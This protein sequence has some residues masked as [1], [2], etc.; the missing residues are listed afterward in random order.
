MRPI[1]WNDGTKFDDV[2]ARWGSP[3]YVLEIGD[4]G[5][6][7]QPEAP[8]T[9][10]PRKHNKNTMS[11]NATPTNRTILASLARTI[12]TGQLSHGVTIGLHHHLAPAM[13]T[14]IKKLEGDPAAAAGSAANKGSQLVYR[15]AVDATGDAEA[16]LMTLSDTTVKTWLEGYRKIMSGVHGSKANAGW[17]AAGFAQG[18]TAIPRNH[19]QRHVLLSA[20]R[21]YLAAHAN[22]EGS[23]PQPTGP[24]LAITA[25]RA[26]VLHTD[27]QAAKTLI[28]TTTNAQTTAKTLRDADVDALYDEVSDTIAELHEVLSD[29]DPL[30]EIFGLNIPA[31]PNPPLGISTLT[32]TAAGTGRELLSWPYA[33]RAEYYRVF[34]KRVGIDTDFINVDD[35]KDLE[36]TLKNLTPGSII[37]VY[38]V[39]MNDGGAGPASP[40]V[41]KTVGA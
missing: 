25:A 23:L 6:I 8:G 17:V 36:Y 12:L 30:W 24:A 5:Y 9:I 29:T 39:P 38:V 4:P 14:A 21:A 11:S 20:A 10:S 2:N 28:T 7:A 33:V 22:Y 31:N 27:M 15:D 19:D 26:L 34:L 18:T 3:S 41:S 32:I 13:D 1:R 40:T 35:P 37:E 16:A